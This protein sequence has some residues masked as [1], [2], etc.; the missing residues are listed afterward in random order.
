[1]AMVPEAKYELD[2]LNSTP[3]GEEAEEL[4]SQNL[5]RI[6]EQFLDR[7]FDSVATIPS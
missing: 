1:M 4:A 6:T 3:D 5:Q 7:L 2:P